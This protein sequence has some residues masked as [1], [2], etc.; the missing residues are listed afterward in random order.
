MSES[1]KREYR[2]VSIEDLLPG[3][4]LDREVTS[5]SD[6]KTLLE[7]GVEL[8][9]TEI[10][11]LKQREIYSVRVK[12][13][14]FE[15]VREA[16]QEEKL[17]GIEFSSEELERLTDDVLEEEK[18]KQKE[19]DQKRRDFYQKLRNFTASLFGDIEN[20]N[21]IDVS[22]IRSMV[23][24]LISRMNRDLQETIQLTRLRDDEH[25]LYSHTINVT[26]LSLHLAN[27]LDLRSNQLEQLGVGTM[28][29]DVGMTQIPDEVLLKEDLL[30]DQ[31]FRI[32]QKHPRFKEELLRNVSGLS[33]FARSVVLQH[34][35]RMDGSGYP[36]GMEGSEISKFARLVAVTDSYD[37]M[38]NPRVYSERRTSYDAM[39]VII[40]EGGNLYDKKM[41]RYFFQNMAIYPIG[42]VVELS[43]DSVAVV[44]DT[45]DAPLRPSVKVILDSDG[46]KLKPAPIL[47][48][49]KNRSISISRVLDQIN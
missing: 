40:R 38:V 23:S 10:R 37:A 18:E 27:A 4:V 8:T 1:T 29:H 15:K 26:I 28:L 42:S 17:D 2:S 20:R 25:Y 34:H 11:R 44:H 21:H 13:D 48:L 3:M 12:S 24:T 33:Y 35:E 46:K 41:A 5:A 9:E 36:I 16:A 31:E 32:I 39:Q 19:E 47:N 49:M 6:N 14:S 45:T 7:E 30:T 22:G 43:D